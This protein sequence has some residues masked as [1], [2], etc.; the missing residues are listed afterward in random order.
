MRNIFVSSFAKKEMITYTYYTFIELN[1][2]VKINS[3]AKGN[4]FKNM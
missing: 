1:K 4:F 3:P 2:N